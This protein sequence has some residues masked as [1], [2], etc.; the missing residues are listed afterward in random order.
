MSK[1]AQTTADAGRA[2]HTAGPWRTQG[3][4]PTW[5]YIPVHDANHNLVASLYPNIARGYTREQVE[6]NAHL[7]VALPELVSALEFYA[8]PWAWKKL[9]DPD[10]LVRIPDF[11]SE[12]SFGDT[13]RAAL[14]AATTGG[15]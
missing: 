8:D 6:A 10:D 7:V 3:W 13:A 14:A 2:E 1:A 15:A 4:V 9:H 12:T 5:A 11:Y